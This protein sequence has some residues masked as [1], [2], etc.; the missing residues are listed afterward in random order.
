MGWDPKSVE[1]LPHGHGEVFPAFLTWRGAVD[2]RVIDL[3][4]PLFAAGLRPEV[5]VLVC[6]ILVFF[7]TLQS[8]LTSKFYL[9][10]LQSKN[11]FL[12]GSKQVGCVGGEVPYIKLGDFGIARVLMGTH[13]QA[14]TF[15][16]T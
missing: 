4:R 12:D 14:T 10:T 7:L 5:T 15:A 13:E 11:V 9:L 8:I 6:G 3:M 1:R 2:K 16:G